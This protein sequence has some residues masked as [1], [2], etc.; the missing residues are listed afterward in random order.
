MIQVIIGG[1]K[2]KKLKV[3][4]YNIAKKNEGIRKLLRNGLTICKRSIYF[5]FYPM[6][7]NKKRVIFEVF[8]GRRYAD[9]PKAIYE[10][11]LN[12]LEYSDYEF[13]W[14]FLNPS[15]FEKEFSNKPRTK[16]VTRDSVAYYRYYATSKY[17]IV[18]SRVPEFF[19]KKSQ[20]VL[21][22]CWHGTPLK[23]LG[24]DI[25]V[26]KGNAMNSISDIRQKWN[27]DTK[28][29]D[30]L[31]SPSKFCTEK[32]TSAFNLKALNKENIMIE[33]GYPRND[34]IVNHSKADVERVKQELQIPSDKKVILYAPTFR[35][36]Q[37]QSGVGYTYKTSLDFDR[38]QK[39]FG[40]EYVVLFRAH[41]FV[42]NAFDF[43][44]YEGFV[45]NVSNYNDIN[46]LYIISD[47]LITDYSSVF[48]DYSLLKR[49]MI[50]YMYDLQEYQNNLRDFYF[51]IDILPGPI[52][53]TEDALFKAIDDSKNYVYD[54]KCE[55][56]RNMFTYLD[57]GKATERVVKCIFAKSK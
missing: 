28:Q 36:N 43:K 3:I 38:F 16:L 39:E 47:L 35:D 54:E 17:W 56:F 52:V 5:L 6:K 22:Q 2:M 50:Y 20:Q 23:R 8:S 33:Q 32:F 53:E 1:I 41:Y 25:E 29:Y 14:V 45:Y 42:A 30:Y 31:I 26:E 51:S 9:S 40:D 48:F 37:H 44:K 15:E 27:A 21:T 46:D 55:A 7:V 49:P 24:F 11:M 34:A 4:L 13:I 57:D 19:V 12:N 18:N 10:Y